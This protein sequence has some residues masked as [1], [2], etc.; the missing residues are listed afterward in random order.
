MDK[1]R[2]R[3]DAN[4]KYFVGRGLDAKTEKLGIE[5]AT[6]NARILAIEEIFGVN[7]SFSKQAQETLKDIHYQKNYS[8][9]APSVQM[10]GF[11]QMD[12]YTKETT[13][14]IN[15]W[16]LFRYSKKEIAKEKERQQNMASVQKKNTAKPVPPPIVKNPVDKD[17]DDSLTDYRPTR[18]FTSSILLSMGGNALAKKDHIGT[19]P[20]AM[21]SVLNRFALTSGKINALQLDYSMEVITANILN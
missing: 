21:A 2:P 14:G 1:T 19:I 10:F 18:Y 20:F 5:I 9:L 4:Y 13:R 7:I 3:E 6:Q 15:T 11:E 17:K 12:I 8:E 16:M